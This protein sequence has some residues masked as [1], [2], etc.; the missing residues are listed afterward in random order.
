MVGVEVGEYHH[1]VLMVK[2]FLPNQQIEKIWIFTVQK[3]LY[4][5]CIEN[6]DLFYIETLS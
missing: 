1:E 6:L 5:Y 4:L 2:F 3:N